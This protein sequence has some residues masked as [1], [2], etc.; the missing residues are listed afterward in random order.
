MKIKTQ[1][2]NLTGFAEACFDCNSIDEL[3]NALLDG[4]ADRKDCDRWNITEKEWLH[5]VK[6][7]LECLLFRNE[8]FLK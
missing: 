8:S 6:D 3:I 1:D 2:H 4:V 7:A 5:D